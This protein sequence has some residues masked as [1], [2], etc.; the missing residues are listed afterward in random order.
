MSTPTPRLDETLAPPRRTRRDHP[1]LRS[2]A[3]LIGLGVLVVMVLSCVLTLPW[4]LAEVDGSPRYDQQIKQARHLPPTWW[5]M[6]DSER[7]RYDAATLELTIR[8]VARALALAGGEAAQQAVATRAGLDIEQVRAQGVAPTAAATTPI[9][10]AATNNGARGLDRQRLEVWL[11][12]QEDT[13]A[14]SPPALIREDFAP[15]HVMGTDVL[16][17]DLFVRTLTGGGISLG[18]GLAA[19]GLSVFLGTAYGMI[20]GYAGGRID[21]VMMRVVD[22]LYGLPYILLVVL[23]AVASSAVVDEWQSRSR[24]REAFIMQLASQEAASRG[25]ATDGATLRK[26]RGDDEALEASLQAKAEAEPSLRRR[27]LSRWQRLAL[28]L[29]TLLVA[30]GGVS[31]LTMSRVVRGQVLSLKSQPFMEAARAIG[32]PLHRQLLR[33][34]LPNIVGVV[35][36]YATLTVPQAI[37]QESFLSFL[38]IGVKQPLPSW[39]SLAADGLTELNPVRSRWWMLVF[40]CLLLG[41]TLL[42]LNFMGEGLR[43]A[44]DPRLS[45]KR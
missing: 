5:P 4:T 10:A 24:A 1:L 37:L 41:V 6:D 14:W 28:D 16:G 25:V 19:A 3:G 40:P 7:A 42:S 43:E 23:L 13:G 34:L 22:V 12:T 44:L 15:F 18:V 17:R 35:V 45:R 32:V 30:I 38:G 27:E 36:V 8:G 20:A 31:W 2:T 33:H 9:A 29:G 39:G 11:R 26:L 21:A